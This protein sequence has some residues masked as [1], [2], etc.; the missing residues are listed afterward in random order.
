MYR[1]AEIR[2]IDLV[3]LV[4]LV[5][6]SSSSVLVH[7]WIDSNNNYDFTQYAMS[8]NTLKASYHDRNN[9]IIMKKSF[10]SL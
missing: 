9:S 8:I 3:A 7:G 4:D 10:S 5:I 6:S 2:N 1:V